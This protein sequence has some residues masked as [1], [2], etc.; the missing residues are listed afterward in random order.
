MFTKKIPETTVR[1][2]SAYFRLLSFLEKNGIVSISSSG[3]S[4]RLGFTD[5][6]IR[7]DFSYFGQFGQ[8]G[9]GYPVSELKKVMA[10]ILGLD[11][12]IWNVALV[13]VGNLGSALLTYKGF[14]QQGFFI[15]TAFDINP[16]KIG[17]SFRGIK[18]ES[19]KKIS[20]L[21]KEKNITIGI[22]AVPAEAAQ[23]VANILSQSGIRGIINFAPLR[24]NVHSRII[25]RNVDLSMELEN[26]SY[27]LATKRK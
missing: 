24:I 16:R 20:S 7:R 23:E 19:L 17:R 8:S 5:A 9:I 14:K 22:I 27:F 2:L 26:I 15:K 4:Q 21:V 18:I 11:N 3:L 25:V 10:K 1:R 12:K 13:G 6:Q